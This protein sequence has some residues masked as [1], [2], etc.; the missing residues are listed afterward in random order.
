MEANIR[1]DECYIDMGW[2]QYR[3]GIEYHGMHHKRQLEEDALRGNTLVARD[4]RILE[5]YADTIDGGPH[6]FKFFGQVARALTAAGAAEV[7]VL[8]EPMT[9]EQACGARPRPGRGG[10][11]LMGIPTRPGR[12]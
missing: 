6:E 9:L 11:P 3:V 4:W 10:V 5:A 1:V 7:R 2:P 12:Q 8:H